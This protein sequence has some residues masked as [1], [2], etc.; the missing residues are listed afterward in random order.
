M[1][2]P[3]LFGEA[4][5]CMDMAGSTERS[6]R[7][8]FLLIMDELLALMHPVMYFV[9]DIVQLLFCAAVHL[10][11]RR[12]FSLWC[13]SCYGRFRMVLYCTV[14]LATFTVE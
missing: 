14:T 7:F 12:R 2:V 11:V 5:S 6:L 3:D 8:P 1:A 13:G 4:A 9:F 10:A